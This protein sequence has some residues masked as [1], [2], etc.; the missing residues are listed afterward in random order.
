[1]L[2]KRAPP[3]MRPVMK[4]VSNQVLDAMINPRLKLPAYLSLQVSG[5]IPPRS[6][7]PDPLARR[8]SARGR[9]HELRV[10]AARGGH[11]PSPSASDVVDVR[12][13]AFCVTPGLD[14]A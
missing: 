14:L 1:M 8:R 11:P 6:S 12:S 2:P 10:N 5:K 7:Y 3:L 13:P 4:M 9:T